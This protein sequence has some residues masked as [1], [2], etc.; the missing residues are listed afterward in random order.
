M[1][2][3]IAV[4]VLGLIEGITEF[5]P[6]SS[7]G[8]LLL[9]EYAFKEWLG[10]PQRSDLFNTVIQCGAVLAVVVLFTRRVEQML[11]HWRDPAV[12]RFLLKLAAAFAITGVGGLILKKT[13]LELPETAGPV[14]WAT[15]VGGFVIFAVERWMKGRTPE[16][17]MGWVS[18]VVAGLAQLLAA[19]FPG[20]SRSGATILAAMVAGTSRKSATEFSFLLGIPTLLSA[21]VF[22]IV[23]A[24][25]DAQAQSIAMSENWAQLIVAGVVAAITAFAAVEWLL[26]FVQHHTFIAFVWYRIGLGLLILAALR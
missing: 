19:A 15:L 22:Q 5:L 13:G 17:E 3:W 6:V 7:T 21:G 25:R 8:H 11:F 23:D 16:E 26:K 9:A 14:A 10:L 24:W 2:E 4:I 1:A 20:T 18:A 12:R